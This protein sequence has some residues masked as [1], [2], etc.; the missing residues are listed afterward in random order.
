MSD[1]INF[2]EARK[3]KNKMKYSNLMDSNSKKS[4]VD[5]NTMNNFSNL[6]EKQLEKE[7][8]DIREANTTLKLN[9]DLK[10]IVDGEIHKIDTYQ[11]R[12]KLWF[13]LEEVCKALNI[14]DFQVLIDVLSANWWI[15]KLYRKN[16][17]YNIHNIPYDVILIPEAELYTAFCH[18]KVP[19]NYE[20]IDWEIPKKVEF[21]EFV[22]N[23]QKVIEI[24]EEPDI[25]YRPE[26]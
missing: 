9:E 24:I 21:S 8:M 4:P 11:K 1:V 19:K 6:T 10:L 5:I 15:G 25:Y 16:K 18:K 3:E 13:D 14:K 22:M 12:S 23:N 17:E 7:F 26:L 20:N 2:E